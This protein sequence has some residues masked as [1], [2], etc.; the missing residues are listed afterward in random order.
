V[1][2]EKTEKIRR[3]KMTNISNVSK[4]EL[5][6]TANI[7]WL[8][9]TTTSEP[10]GALWLGL[11]HGI[12]KSGDEKG[13]MFHVKQWQ[14]LGYKGYA[15]Q[16]IRYG[17]SP[18]LGYIMILSGRTSAQLWGCVVGHP[19][20]ITRIDLACTVRLAFE[21]T[22]L[23]KTYFDQISKDIAE[24]YQKGGRKYALIQNTDQGETLYVGSRRSAQFGR[25]YDKGVQS[26]NAPPGFCWRYEVEYKKPLSG[27]I[28]RAVAATREKEAAA[29]QA[30]VYD[31]FYSRG[32]TPVFQGDG[33]GVSIELE[34]KIS[35]PEKK[36][37]W[38]RKQV[39]PSVMELISGGRSEECIEA[40]GLAG[41]R[42]APGDEKGKFDNQ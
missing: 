17:F 40:L 20:K 5:I 23:A 15:L 42:W 26:G 36:L 1:G 37:A 35:T 2:D 28:A 22:R 9:C 27:L 6:T 21:H 11:M 18:K 29:I 31:W 32:V 33:S 12:A 41:Y 30:T 24:G 19:V 8:T 4:E 38:L 25:V 7:D 14:A 13:R 39:R 10:R 16:G 3:N 34:T